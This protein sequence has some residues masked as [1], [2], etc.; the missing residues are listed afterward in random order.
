MKKHYVRVHKSKEGIKKEDQLAWK[1]A[2]CALDFSA[3][4]LPSVSDMVINRIIDNAAVAIASLERDSVRHARD[5]ALQFPHPKG[6]LIFGC[7]NQK[8]FFAHWA[9]WANGVAVRELDFHDA[10]FATD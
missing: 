6:A 2:E 8:R 9:A 3:P 4:L 5:Q 10:F 7:P 1:I